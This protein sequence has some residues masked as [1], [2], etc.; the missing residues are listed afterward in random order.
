VPFRMG[1][2][3]IIEH[4]VD[5]G[6]QPTRRRPVFA[7]EVVDGHHSLMVG[8]TPIVGLLLNM[9]GS[10]VALDQGPARIPKLTLFPH[11]DLSPH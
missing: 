7:E 8:T 3:G 10:I 9:E 2:L 6:L 11:N 5:Q 1:P 4:P